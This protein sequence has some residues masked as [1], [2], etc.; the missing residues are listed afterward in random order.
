M[1][2]TQSSVSSDHITEVMK[3]NAN[4]SNLTFN[5]EMPQGNEEKLKMQS[6]DA[7][8]D[9][10]VSS[11]VYGEGLASKYGSVV[12]AN[13]PESNTN[14]FIV[15]IVFLILFILISLGIGIFYFTQTKK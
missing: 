15:V 3:T 9:S 5:K 12:S 6:V 4:K 7:I 13:E 1:G 10:D 14:V 11:K 2:Q 8:F